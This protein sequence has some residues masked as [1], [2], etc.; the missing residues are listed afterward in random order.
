V[1]ALARRVRPDRLRSLDAI[2][3]ASALV[4]DA[5]V[6]LTYDERLARACADNGLRV[7]TP[8]TPQR[9]TRRRGK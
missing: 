9:A 1:T 2:H 7:A 3:L 4:I 5:D 6:V 8:G